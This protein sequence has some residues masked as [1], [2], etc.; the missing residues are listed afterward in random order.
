MHTP[1]LINYII[2]I[3]PDLDSCSA[4]STI[5]VSLF[6]FHPHWQ[7]DWQFQKT[8]LFVMAD[9]HLTKPLSWHSADN[10]LKQFLHKIN[11]FINVVVCLAPVIYC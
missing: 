6:P 5:S 2:H 3:C 11:I 7:G 9:S 1:E 10:K 4:D 8:G